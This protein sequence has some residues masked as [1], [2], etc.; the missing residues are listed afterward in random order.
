M[1]LTDGQGA[2][3]LTITSATKLFSYILYIVKFSIS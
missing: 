2:V 1:H 3:V